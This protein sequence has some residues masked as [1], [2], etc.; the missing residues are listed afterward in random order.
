MFAPRWSFVTLLFSGIF[1][2]VVRIL[3]LGR[4]V[5]G[6]VGYLELL[7]PKV[8]WMQHERSPP[9]KTVEATV[10]PAGTSYPGWVMQRES[11]A[12]APTLVYVPRMQ[13]SSFALSITR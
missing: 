13:P 12:F 11:S 1:G 2:I 5:S 7:V 8:L 6:P 3:I 4:L 10:P 9:A